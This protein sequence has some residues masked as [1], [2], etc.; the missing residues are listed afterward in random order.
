MSDLTKQSELK[1]LALKIDALRKRRDDMLR[2][3]NWIQNN[4]DEYILE[5]DT[6]WPTISNALRSS[7]SA[8]VREAL[9]SAERKLS[10]YVGVCKGDKELTE[11]VLPMLR[12]A[13]SDHGVQNS[14]AGANTK[15]DGGVEADTRANETAKALMAHPSP[16]GSRSCDEKTIACGVAGVAPGPSDPSPGPDVREALEECKHWHERHDKA[17][18]KS[19]RGDADYYWRRDQH[20]QEIERIDTILSAL[21]RPLGGSAQGSIATK[22]SSSSTP[23]TATETSIDELEPWRDE[24]AE[25]V[26]HLGAAIIQST[27]SDDQIIMDHVKAAHEIAKIVRRKA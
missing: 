26:G 6:Q 25:I 27:T 15:S 12:S 17:L 20:R 14:A 3:N 13:L 7:A 5:L 8:G 9:E 11:V 4:Q 22:R 23:A 2:S 21:T 1:E 19:G 10:A 24:L 16:M 18:S